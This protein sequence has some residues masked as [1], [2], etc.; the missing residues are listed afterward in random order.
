[1]SD[2]RACTADD[3]P[4]VARM[5]QK[6]FRDPFE[7][8]PPALESYLRELFLEHPWRDPDTTSRVYV[9][10]DGIVQGF[11]G[12]LPLRMSFHGQPVRAALASSLMVDN[13]AEHPLA[14]ARLL[15]SYLTGPH[16]LCVSE[17]S[18]PIAQGMWERIGGRSIA[19]YSMEW[20]R[21]LRPASLGVAL[22][23]ECLPSTKILHPLAAVADRVLA[24]IAPSLS[25]SAP[26]PPS[27]YTAADV[28][29]DALIEQIPQFAAHYALHPEWDRAALGFFLR[30][31]ARKGR[32]GELY[33]RMVY[34]RN[35]TPV[36]CYLYYGRPRQIAFVL[37][38]L[39]LPEALDAVVA[40]LLS[41][42]AQ[43][44]CAAVRGRTQPHLLDV[45][46]RQ[47][48]VFFQRSSTTVYTRNA[49][50]MSAI[51]TGDAFIIGLAGESWTRLI[52][53]KF[54]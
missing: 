9:D 16:D 43:H 12:V 50:L 10:A 13:P 24:R 3:I 19:E 48:C 8:A 39:A 52:G 22:I 17:T 49:D 2:V 33:R 42:A 20:L 23:G 7:A 47:R 1:M 31:A 28:D 14:G 30:H 6:A 53:E 40:S 18:N 37:Q 5:F 32:H 27:I 34:G 11:I 45:L 26:V 15:R 29:D 21:P 35:K 25:W 38:V 51:R 41:H 4:A 36:G 46:L 44:G 54:A